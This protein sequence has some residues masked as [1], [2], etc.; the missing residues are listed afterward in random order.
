MET[1]HTASSIQYVTFRGYS[2][3]HKHAHA[4]TNPI[5]H[6]SLPDLDHEINLDDGEE[7]DDGN[8]DGD[9]RGPEIGNE[10]ERADNE[11]IKED[12]NV[13]VYAFDNDEADTDEQ[14]KE[15]GQRYVHIQRHTYFV[16]IICKLCTICKF[17]IHMV[18][19]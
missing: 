15:I 13:G 18:N 3:Q 8:A 4:R 16:I 2:T 14:D 9:E 11:E 1:H 17:S 5:H 12:G 6:T 7:G 19:E 10:D